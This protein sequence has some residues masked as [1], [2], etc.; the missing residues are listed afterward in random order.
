MPINDTAQCTK[1]DTLKGNGGKGGHAYHVQTELK[2]AMTSEVELL[3]SYTHSS[4]NRSNRNELRPSRD[5]LPA[6]L[7]ATRAPD[8]EKRQSSSEFT[9]SGTQSRRT[10]KP[11]HRTFARLPRSTRSRPGPKNSCW[12]EQTG[13][14]VTSVGVGYCFF[15]QG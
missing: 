12:A 6:R 8:E 10:K 2:Q 4:R 14:S 15:L 3:N 1:A 11:A 5:S 9:K 7:H 13:T